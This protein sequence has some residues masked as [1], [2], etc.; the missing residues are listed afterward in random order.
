MRRPLGWHQLTLDAVCEKLRTNPHTGLTPREVGSRSDKERNTLFDAREGKASVT[1][2]L[3][4]SL[5]TD[6]ALL[7]LVAAVALSLLFSAWVTRLFAGL[8]FVIYCVLIGRTL[9][10]R[11]ALEK[12]LRRFRVPTVQVIRGGRLLTIPASRVVRGDLLF[13]R[14]G[15]IVPCDCRLVSCENL[16]VATLCPD[17]KGKP[18]YTEGGKNAATVY[19]PDA[20]VSSPDAENLLFGGSEIRAG[21]ARAIAVEIGI[22]TY[23]GAMRGLS[24]P[25]EAVT[26]G[27]MTGGMKGLFR[28]YGFLMLAAFFVLT[29]VGLL[30]APGRY[31][32][33]DVFLM[34]GA[35]LG[36]TSPAALLT[37]L[38]IPETRAI[39]GALR[40]RPRE[41][42]AAIKSVRAATRLSSMTDLFAVGRWGCT[43]GYPHLF[44][45]AVREGNFP[46][47]T[48]NPQAFLQPL[49]EAYLIRKNH[50]ALTA[51]YRDGDGADESVLSDE[52]VAASGF[53]TEAL[54]LRLTRCEE[55]PCND[56][57]TVILDVEM[58][59]GGFRL[60]YSESEGLID[61]CPVSSGTER[62][63]RFF[64]DGIAAGAR[65]TAIAKQDSFGRL[66]MLGLYAVREA[67]SDSFLTSLSELSK[68]GVRTSIFLTGDPFTERRY[69]DYCRIPGERLD[70]SDRSEL[71]PDDLDRYRVFLSVK[72]E[73]IA[74][75][76]TAMRAKKRTVALLGGREEDRALMRLSALSIGCD[77]VQLHKV[78]WEEEVGE[79]LPRD[80]QAQSRKCSQT[81]RRQCDVL[82]PRAVGYGGGLTA[83]LQAVLHCRTAEYRT[84]LLFRF[85]AASQFFALPLAFLAAF[86]GVGMMTFVPWM[87]GGILLPLVGCGFLLSTPIPRERLARSSSMHAEDVLHEVGDRS[88][89]HPSAL[90]AFLDFAFLFL[91]YRM[92]VFSEQTTTTLV[93]VSFLLTV[94]GMLFAEFS[95]GG[96]MK[97]NA[98]KFLIPAVAILLLGGLSALS[99]FVGVVGLT[100]GLGGWTIPALISIPFPLLLYAVARIFFYFLIDRK[101]SRIE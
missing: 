42:R 95:I 18:T 33:I 28:V 32:P 65:V 14:A 50:S 91:L 16:T 67:P 3:L 98:R 30:T 58:R 27:S 61:R 80:G 96:V 20:A 92:G 24:V 15:D 38:R 81:V 75:L 7:L 84:R 47:D 5:L 89:R 77:N 37:L 51:V 29:A 66:T 1:F 70:C 57:S 40:N 23:I 34:N 99:Y 59:Q 93:S 72:E 94:T 48:S 90:A 44:Q 11:R 54:K 63:H 17:A 55:I 52:F 36:M 39:F 76:L 100:T 60:I 83:I 82:I 53:D 79:N 21:V 88:L 31:D 26:G 56:P 12:E 46:P 69:A 64:A 45:C 6:P 8:L 13:L 73:Q 43:D 71:T 87:L 86:F 101:M 49:C 2:G 19:P 97:K 85:L 74:E 62:Y 35:I 68:L 25:A 10:R 4:R 41:N 22:R 9:V 78:A